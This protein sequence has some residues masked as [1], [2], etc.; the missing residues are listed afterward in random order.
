MARA[1]MHGS[2][3]K[4]TSVN[5]KMVSSTAEASGAAPRTLPA[6]YMKVNTLKTRGKARASSH[7][8]AEMFTE[9][10]IETKRGMDKAK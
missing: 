9:A 10:N 3:V 4:S 6:M 7:G 1:S 2:K 5:S 8:Q